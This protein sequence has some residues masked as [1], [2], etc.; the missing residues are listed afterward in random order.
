MLKL[1][2]TRD[3]RTRQCHDGA[4][5]TTPERKLR[6]RSTQQRTAR[7]LAAI[8]LAAPESAQAARQRKQAHEHA[9]SP[10]QFRPPTGNRAAQN[11]K[12][13]TRA[14]DRAW[15]HGTRAQTMPTSTSSTDDVYAA[16]ARRA[17]TMTSEAWN[18]CRARTRACQ[19]RELAHAAKAAPIRALQSLK[20]Q[21]M[22][23]RRPPS[24]TIRQSV[25]QKGEDGPSP[26]SPTDEQERQRA[27]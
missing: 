4:R 14:A 21:K 1:P 2:C 17:S 27:R 3:A 7:R 16:H 10:A 24:R 22:Q 25:D 8:S 13:I 11:R 6:A 23:Q 9:Q 15:Q 18:L 5:E 26:Q 12:R 19:R 20:R